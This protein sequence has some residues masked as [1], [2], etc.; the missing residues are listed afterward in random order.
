VAKKPRLAGKELYHHIYAWGNDRHPVFKSDFHYKK[1]L[2]FLKTY[3]S[4]NGVDVIAYALMETHIHLFIFDK[5][6]K[7]SYFMNSLHGLY[8]QFYNR[9][10]GRVGHVFGERFNNKI[11]QANDYGLWLS[12]YIHRQAVEAGIVNNPKDYPWTSYQAYIG[13]ASK[14]FLKPDV[15][16]EQFGSGKAALE[17][18]R[19]FVMSEEDG[20]INW[21]ETTVLIIGDEAFV[22]D[23]E[24][25]KDIDQKEDELESQDLIG[26][27]I[28][29]LQVTPQVLLNPR[30]WSERRLRHEAF[31]IL[32]DK[33][34]FSIRHV[35][36]VFNISPTSIVKVLKKERSKV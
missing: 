28:K 34:G 27:V 18:Y 31:K 35:A 32:I 5:L 26:I 25:S 19:E 13:L 4:C 2:E 29:E 6:G 11:V 10:S 9:L 30:G 1:Y 8:A 21:Q 17:R 14:G 16:L 15:I 12:R 33:Y 7:I 3:A 36:R 20:P 24:E 23:V 22:N